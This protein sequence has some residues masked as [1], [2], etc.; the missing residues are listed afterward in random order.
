MLAL[1]P[2]NPALTQD[3]VSYQ[4]ADAGAQ[5]AVVDA[6]TREL[7]KD[8]KTLDVADILA[9][10]SATGT[11][12]ESIP[13]PRPDDLALLIYTSGTT[14]RPKGVRL[15]HA[16]VDAMTN[17]LKAAL[18]FTTSGSRAAGATAVSCQRNHDQRRG[19]VSRGRLRDAAAQV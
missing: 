3:E 8:I 15:D 17:A 18:S 1:T 9:R 14:G 7:V 19:T 16:N 2:V 10:E 5:V 13:S 6:G 4:L 11:S 12:S